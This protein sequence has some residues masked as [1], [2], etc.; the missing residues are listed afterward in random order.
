MINVV[1]L[2]FVFVVCAGFAFFVHAERCHR[3][4]LREVLEYDRRERQ[5]LLD[6]IMARNYY[7]LK[8]TEA[9]TEVTQAELD[10]LA[11][12][13]EAQPSLPTIDDVGE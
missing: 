2:L 3:A 1:S 13:N 11:A 5:Q 12:L 10:R 4:W 8:S 7:E 6:R 9:L